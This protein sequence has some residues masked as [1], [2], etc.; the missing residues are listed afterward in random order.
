MAVCSEPT[1]A[2]LN[3]NPSTCDNTVTG[4]QKELFGVAREEEL[5]QGKRITKTC[6]S[7]L[8]MKEETNNLDMGEIPP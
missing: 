3:Q 7:C 6:C 2:K 5:D 4:K 8:R 1:P